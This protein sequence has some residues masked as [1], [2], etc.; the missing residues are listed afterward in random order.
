MVLK[1]R[2]LNSMS[3]KKPYQT[4]EENSKKAV[5]GLHVDSDEEDADVDV[6]KYK[7]FKMIAIP[8]III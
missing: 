1:E 6:I 7:I 2:V 5:F 3:K 4:K 8:L